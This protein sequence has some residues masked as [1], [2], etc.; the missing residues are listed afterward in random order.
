ML[1]G[2][3]FE[4]IVSDVEAGAR[5]DALLAKHCG[6]LSRVQL[7]RAITAGAVTVDGTRPK[8][9]YRVNAGQK[10]RLVVPELPQAVPQAES[11][12]LDI[13]F[14]D[15]YLA[16]INKPPGMVVHPSK[17]H[18]GGTLVN[19]LCTISRSSAA[20]VTPAVPGSCTAWIVIRP[21]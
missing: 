17:G 11:I 1:T 13:L 8:P 4:F 5:L 18:G 20:L 9:S 2:D 19:A 12:P 16:A 7:R 10:V 14:E 15:E 6:A 21:A 3:T